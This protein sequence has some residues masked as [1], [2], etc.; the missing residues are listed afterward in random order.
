ML[1]VPEWIFDNSRSFDDRALEVFRYQYE[2][3]PVYQRY[4]DAL[5]VSVDDVEHLEDIPLLPVQ[6]FKDAEVLSDEVDEPELVFAS[7][8]TSSMERSRHPVALE[9][10]YRQSVIRGFKEF[11]SLDKLIIWAYLPGYEENPDSSLIKMVQILMEQDDSGMSRFLPLDEP[12]DEQAVN[13]VAES[14]KNLLLFG[15][16]FG[17]MDLAEDNEI[18]LP[19]NSTIIETGGMK[20]HR[21]EMS[22]YKM[23]QFMSERFD[24]DPAKIHSEY[25]MAEMLSQAYAMGGKWFRPASWLQAGIYDPDDYSMPLD[26]GQEGLIGVMDLANY[27]SC[28]FLLTGDRGSQRNNGDFQVM[29]RWNPGNLRGCNFL[30]DR[31]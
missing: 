28:S 1:E 14:D 7:S 10:L 17:L 19:I 25:G 15:A 29:G 31:D 4:C 26:Y 8:G 27:Y 6:A 24:I 22:R 11:Y 13:E 18:S 9:E 23:H 20:T 12:L 5:G 21:R 30:I 16:A 2:H 3:V